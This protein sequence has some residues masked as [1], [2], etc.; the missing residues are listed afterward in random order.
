MVQSSRRR[1]VSQKRSARNLRNVKNVRRKKTSRKMKKM[2]RSKRKT[3]LKSKHK[4]RGGSEFSGSYEHQSTKDKT[5]I[6]YYIMGKGGFGT[7]QKRLFELKKDTEDTEQQK[8][9]LT[10][11]KLIPR[12]RDSPIIGMFEFTTSNQG[13][14]F[15]DNCELN[16]DQA[17]KYTANGWQ[18]DPSRGLRVKLNKIPTE[19]TRTLR[20]APTGDYSNFLTD[21]EMKPQLSEQERARQERESVALA[22]A[23]LEAWRGGHGPGLPS[24]IGS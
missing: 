2:K 13:R 7:R 18:P 21:T 22:A 14:I 5:L 8:F 16:I 1:K 20:S 17:W 15:S 4:M 10:Y 23:E 12:P 11:G 9:Y 19:D 6:R 3:S 24:I